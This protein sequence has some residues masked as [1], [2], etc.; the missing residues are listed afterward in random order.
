[1]G[2]QVPLVWV[3][4]GERWSKTDN[5]R[6]CPSTCDQFVTIVSGYKIPTFGY[7][8]TSKAPGCPIPR[9]S[10]QAPAKKRP[11][12]DGTRRASIFLTDTCSGVQNVVQYSTVQYR[13]CQSEW[14]WW[15]CAQHIDLS[16]C[17]G[18]EVRGAD[19]LKVRRLET[20]KAEQSTLR[21]TIAFVLYAAHV[22][23]RPGHDIHMEHLRFFSWPSNL[24][25]W[26]AK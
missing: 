21:F 15:S 18:G 2:A 11:P 26:G 14:E 8:H 24:W 17:L 9:S 13:K 25:R 10:I 7:L 23:Y 16:R 12:V 22:S 6:R 4:V 20:H 1:M 19:V 5:F 3:G